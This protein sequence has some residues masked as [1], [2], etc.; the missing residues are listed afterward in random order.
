MDWYTQWETHDQ[1]QSLAKELEA[2]RQSILTHPKNQGLSA[3]ACTELFLH[4]TL[5]QLAQRLKS[6][7]SLRPSESRFL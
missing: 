5:A 3:E 7:A 2:L 6:Q 4:K 1:M